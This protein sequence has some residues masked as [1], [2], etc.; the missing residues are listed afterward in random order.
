MISYQFTRNSG[1]NGWVNFADVDAA[2][3][4][5]ATK[6]TEA[7]P[8]LDFQGRMDEDVVVVVVVGEALSEN[9]LVTLTDIV[10]GFVPV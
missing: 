5:L 10:E 6:I 7:F 3:K 9:D 4:K 8:S 1:P 2:G